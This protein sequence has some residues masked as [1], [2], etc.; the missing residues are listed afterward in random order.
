MNTNIYSISSSAVI[1]FN[2]GF[3]KNK[4]KC[5]LWV[6][7]N[8]I[9]LEFLLKN[10]FLRNSAIQSSKNIFC[11]KSEAGIVLNLSLIFEQISAWRPY[12]LG[13]YKK[14][15]YVWKKKCVREGIKTKESAY[16]R[17]KITHIK[18]RERDSERNCF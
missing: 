5:G 8:R 10:M 14:K 2:R 6:H 7:Y 12:K 3:I 1:I 17:E 13:P 18:E 11:L 9:T 4:G 15:V 16:K